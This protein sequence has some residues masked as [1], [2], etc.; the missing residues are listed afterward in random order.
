MTNQPRC[1]KCGAEMVSLSSSCSTATKCHKCGWGWTVDT[2]DPADSDELAYEVWLVPGN[3]TTLSR[4]RLIADVA[5]TNYL[6]AR[7]LLSS[8]TPALVYKAQNYALGGRSK[9]QQIKTIAKQLAD[10]GI[11]FYISPKFPYSF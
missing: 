9:V 6:Q 2:Y 11:M 10:A 8:D 5:N 4:L 3:Q 1:E 7:R